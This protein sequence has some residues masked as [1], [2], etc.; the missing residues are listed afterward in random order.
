MTDRFARETNQQPA[1]SNQRPARYCQPLRAPATI[2]SGPTGQLK[3]MRIALLM[4][5]SLARPSWR[6]LRASATAAN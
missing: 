5:S 4:S 6:I 1:T 3:P 2:S